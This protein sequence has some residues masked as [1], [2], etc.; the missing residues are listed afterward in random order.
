MDS[1]PGKIPRY[2]TW[3]TNLVDTHTL[4]KMAAEKTNTPL[5]NDLSGLTSDWKRIIIKSYWLPAPQ[6]G[7]SIMKSGHINWMED[8]WILIKAIKGCYWL[9]ISAGKCGGP[10][11]CLQLRNMCHIARSLWKIHFSVVVNDCWWGLLGE[12]QCIMVYFGSVHGCRER[13]W[14]LNG[15]VCWHT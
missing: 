7:F 4:G 12:I 9:H 8:I 10:T 13:D 6:W 11:V 3:L 2:E 5:C 1:R 14:P 15:G